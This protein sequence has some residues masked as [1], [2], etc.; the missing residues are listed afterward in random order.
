MSGT[1]K[2]P[3]IG[4]GA[5]DSISSIEDILSSLAW[6]KRLDAAR[7]QRAKVLAE[8]SRLAGAV[9]PEISAPPKPWDRQAAR[10]A[11]P[12]RHAAT[13]GGLMQ[14]A[15]SGLRLA[16]SGGTPVSAAA[17]RPHMRPVDAPRP[18]TLVLVP[19]APEARAAAVLR[20]APLY[21]PRRAA[22]WT[23]F[24]LGLI[25]GI[26]I[27][28]LLAFAASRYVTTENGPAAMP[29]GPDASV[30]PV[31]LAMRG[32]DEPE[33]GE[34]DPAAPSVSSDG[35]VMA[36]RLPRLAEAALDRLPVATPDQPGRPV[37]GQP[38]GLAVLA[39]GTSGGAWSQPLRDA[40]F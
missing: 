13:D 9:L 38:G 31:E 28:A 8:K 18:V 12:T 25:S 30:G 29:R 20:E 11:A 22:L 19:E 3:D 10:Q 1:S 21:E 14:D 34:A 4:S 15:I 23:R 39:H 26:A 27:G 16:A 36:P 37:L 40:T 32:L 17:S 2:A 6:Q 33:A 24:A 5:D 35:T 7:V